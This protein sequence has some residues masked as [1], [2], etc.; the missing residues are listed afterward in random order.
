VEPL[1]PT[2]PSGV[3]NVDV[4]KEMAKLAENQIM[5]NFGIRFAGF[6]KYNSAITG[7]AQ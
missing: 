2:L 7:R 6:D 1:D 5:Y 4:D 3:N